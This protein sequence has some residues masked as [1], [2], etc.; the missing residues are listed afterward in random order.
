VGEVQTFQRDAL[1]WKLTVPDDG[2]LQLVAYA[3]VDSVGR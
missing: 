3:V 2:A 1:S